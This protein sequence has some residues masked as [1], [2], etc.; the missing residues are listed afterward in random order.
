MTRETTKF[1][2]RPA[3]QFYPKDWLSDLGLQACSYAAKGLW[4]DIL[5][6]M[7]FAPA[8]GCVEAKAIQ[9]VSKKS[10]KEFNKTLKELIDKGVCEYVENK[11]VL[12]RK[13]HREYHQAKAISKKRSMAAHARWNA[14]PH[15]KHASPSSSPSSSPIPLPKNNT[16]PPLGNRGVVLDFLLNSWRSKNPIDA[17]VLGLV[18]S[19]RSSLNAALMAGVD[20]K[21]LER[22][23]FETAG[24][25]IKPW[26]IF[27]QSKEKQNEPVQKFQLIGGKNE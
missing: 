3:F 22:K 4:I 19:A 23:I 27:G 1:D 7:W 5:C 2:E 25:G 14:K 16:P 11:Y 12:C 26:E 6:F 10:A 17:A 15:A 8:R 18:K 20:V 24:K 13:M 21:E 9:N